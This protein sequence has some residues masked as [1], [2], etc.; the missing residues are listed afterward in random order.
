MFTPF[1]YTDTITLCSTKLF[2]NLL[3]YTFSLPR[4]FILQTIFVD[5]VDCAES[6]IEEKTLKN[7]FDNSKQTTL[8]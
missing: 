4:D 8:V 6:I 7:V 3:L 2:S 5:F 1:L